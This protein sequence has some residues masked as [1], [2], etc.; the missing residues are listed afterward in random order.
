QDLLK[1]SFS[2]KKDAEHCYECLKEAIALKESDLRH[3]K[4]ITSLKNGR[5]DLEYTTSWLLEH[6]IPFLGIE[7][8]QPALEDVFISLT[9]EN[10]KEVS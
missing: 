1:I 7:I 10:E 9:G 5:K 8:V 2:V 6:G 4:I 3:D